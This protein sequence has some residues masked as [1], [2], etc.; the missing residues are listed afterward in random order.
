[1]T[2]RDTVSRYLYRAFAVMVGLILVTG[3]VATTAAV[4]QFRVVAALTAQVMPE[5][6]A[7]A[8]VRAAL[9]EAQRGIRGY[10]L[11]GDPTLDTVYANARHD[12]TI[13]AADLR[14]LAP[15]ADR[16][17][18][19]LQVDQAGAWL[20]VADDHRRRP[21]DGDRGL[22]FARQ[23]RPLFDQFLASN[24]GLERDLADRS[25][26]LRR[27]TRRTEALAV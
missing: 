10:L 3:V 5:R 6:L 17:A 4:E 19:A 22:A 25:D 15:P 23:A 7:N 27:R 2:G 12:F 21:L 18:V 20:R 16:A 14:R 11:T 8:E 13:A 26:D 9:N 1:M 24:A